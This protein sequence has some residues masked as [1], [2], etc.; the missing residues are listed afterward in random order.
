MSYQKTLYAPKTPPVRGK[1]TTPLNIEHQDRLLKFNKPDI[2]HEMCI[3]FQYL[4][5]FR[6]IIKENFFLDL[7]NLKK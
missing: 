5:I 7:T 4:I 2:I 1:V 6:H 3:F